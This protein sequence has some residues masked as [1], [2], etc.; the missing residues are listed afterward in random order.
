M[1]K[2]LK[3]K[4]SGYRKIENNFT[5]D[6]L[7]LARINEIDLNNEIVQ[8]D[9]RLFTFVAFAFVGSNAS[10]KTTAL[11]LILNCYQLLNT[12]RW[13]YLPKDFSK[14]E[15]QLSIDFFDEGKIYFYEVTL[16][17][18]ESFENPSGGFNFAKI[19]QE[20]LSF[21]PYRSL[22]GKQYEKYRKEATYLEKK[23]TSILDTSSLLLDNIKTKVYLDEFT[24]NNVLDFGSIFY[25]NTFFDTLRNEKNIALTSSLFRLLDDNIES[26]KVLDADYV[27]YKEYSSPEKKMRNEELIGILSDGTIRGSELFL[28]AIQALKHGG[29]LIVDE[30]E[31][32]FH[33]NLVSSLISLFMSKN[34]NPLGAQIL[35]STHYSQ[36]LDV[37]NRRDSIYVLHKI[38]GKITIKNL[39]EYNLRSEISKSAALDNN[40]FDTQVDYDNLMKVK[41]NIE[42]EI[43]SDHDGRTE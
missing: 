8:I 17:K 43:H 26:I 31:N 6:L 19:K 25:R 15:I 41:D 18:P 13:V 37:M 30:I 3:I 35:F 20:S 29:I 2:I 38:H 36:I 32:C 27:L 28:R 11:S 21:I 42:D 34:T 22:F 4:A 7:N 14:D 33:K 1:P 9:K 39:K 40:L 24:N 5:I 10:G 16:V 12:G 23:D